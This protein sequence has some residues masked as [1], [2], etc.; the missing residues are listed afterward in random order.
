MLAG[1]LARR[2]DMPMPAD[3]SRPGS[4]LIAAPRA[5]IALAFL[6]AAAC[7]RDRAGSTGSADLR[8]A[9]GGP[10]EAS[11]V[12]GAE[13]PCG[14]GRCSGICCEDDLAVDRCIDG[15]RVAPPPGCT[16]CDPGTNEPCGSKR[17]CLRTFPGS[18]TGV[19][20]CAGP[21]E[22]GSALP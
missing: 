12:A 5:A 6:A 14:N 9:V 18:T 20:V 3:G 4:G 13:F 7:T 21:T 1:S 15:N 19:W 17:C 2:L 16:A 10:P 11:S 8:G 22:C